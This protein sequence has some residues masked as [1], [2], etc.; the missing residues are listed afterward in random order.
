M[1]MKYGLSLPTRGAARL[2]TIRRFAQEFV[3]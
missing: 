2:E 1:S 3:S